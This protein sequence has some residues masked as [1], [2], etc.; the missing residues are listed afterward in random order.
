MSIHDLWDRVPRRARIAALATVPTVALVVGA[1]VAAAEPGGSGN[2]AALAPGPLL[3]G[4]TVSA[5]GTPSPGNTDGPCAVP[6]GSA[7]PSGSTSA[8]PGDTPSGSASASPSKD[9]K[10]G[11][12][13]LLGGLTKSPTATSSTGGSDAKSASSPASG[14]SGAGKA[15]GSATPSPS[16]TSKHPILDWF[17][18][19]FGINK[20]A[21]PSASA[22]KIS[23]SPSA[24]AGSGAS[25]S[26]T[27]PKSPKSGGGTT[28][29]PS[30]KA[31]AAK[32]KS[33]SPTP[34]PTNTTP[35]PSASAS[36]SAKAKDLKTTDKWPYACPTEMPKNTVGADNGVNLPKVA[37]H[38]NSS[39][40]VLYGLY[41][42]G[43]VKVNASGTTKTV[44]KFTASAVDIGDLDMSAELSNGTTLHVVGGKGTTSTIR[45][46]QVTMYTQDLKG[47]LFGLVPQNYHP[48]FLQDPWFVE[49]I[50][51][52][53]GDL[54]IPATYTDVS[55]DNAGQF[56]GT[57]KIPGMR[58][59]STKG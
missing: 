25:G 59:Y 45:G 24:D 38:L 57:L 23:A 41:Y 54:P 12:G 48:K 13:G 32:S 44:M 34:T 43:I 8:S 7:S 5:T 10:G 36:S 27:S 56:G 58:T 22:T 46:G 29:S 18:N 39:K 55:L 15:A 16:A 21:S 35:S 30:T 47:N 49:P 6:T 52:L 33:A 51:A 53:V 11:K 28:A 42:H 20:S 19:L 17:N 1:G 50:N 9:A 3:R 2:G 31:K 40:L 37:W 26:G 14:S 4:A